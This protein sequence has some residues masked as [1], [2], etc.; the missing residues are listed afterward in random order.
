MINPYMLE[1]TYKRVNNPAFSG[2][3]YYRPVVGRPLR[4]IFRRASEAEKH[5]KRAHALWCQLY[6]WAV[7]A[8]SAVEVEAVEA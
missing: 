6:D 2:G 8:L 7:L 5:A 3:K 4:R 1:P